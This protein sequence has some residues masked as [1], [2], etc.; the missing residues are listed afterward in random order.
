MQTEAGRHRLIPVDVVIIGLNSSPTLAACIESV[1]S[2]Q[3]GRA[4]LRVIYVDGGSTDGSVA[5]A[6]SHPGVKIVEPHPGHPAPG[7]QRNAGWRAGDA[8]FVQ[9]MDAD[10][11]LEPGW[12]DAALEAASAGAGA[13]RGLRRERRPGASV[14]NWIADQE[15]NAPPGPCEDFGGDA[16][17]RREA[18]ERTG[19]YD[20]T[21][22]GGEDPELSRR[23]RALGYSILA[24]DAPMTTHD[25]AMTTWRQYARRAFRTGYGYAAVYHR[26]G[27]SGFW[28]REV[29]RIAVRGG[30]GL[31]CALASAA[32]L[33]AGRPASA[34]LALAACALLV[35]YPRLFSV[36]RMARDKRLGSREAAVYAWHC[37]LVVIPEFFGLARYAFGVL[38]ESPLRNKAPKAAA[39]LLLGLCALTACRGV[40]PV[41]TPRENL[42][43]PAA[44]APT[45]SKE[46]YASPEAVEA[47][48]RMVDDQYRIGPGDILKLQV[49]NRPEI[50]NPNVVVGPDGAVTVNRIG[51]VH[52]GGKTVDQA[53][54]EISSRLGAFYERPEVALSVEKFNNNKAFVLGRVTSPG[55]VHFPGR[56]SLLE[57]LALAGGLPVL[58][59]DAFLTKCSIIR[60]RDT[61]IWVDLRD[62]LNNGNIALNARLQNNDIVFIPESEDELI[63]VMGEVKNPGAIRLKS[64]LTFMDALMMSGG[65]TREASMENIYLVR[66]DGKQGNVIQISLKDMLNTGNMSANYAL[67]A[68]D[69]I[70]VDQTGMSKFNYA[71][72]QIMPSLQILQMGTSIIDMGTSI[73][74]RW[75]PRYDGGSSSTDNLGFVNS[76]INTQ[77]SATTKTTGTGAA[78]G[79]AP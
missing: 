61:I 36:S 75:W 19:G 38:S 5:L 72:Q 39:L 22:V 33:P 74:Q 24:L 50:T 79:A 7:L 35:L 51:V 37:S 63:Y 29:R 67:K 11:T 54:K 53:A 42:T 30:G 56:G 76:I 65:P 68:N 27:G 49:W 52:I 15:W 16:F 9:F 3:T 21:L 10:T 1:L 20:E 70:Y 17:V 41:P 47:F 44:A 71:L 59:K 73:H 28:G 8:P 45:K 55:V 2:H 13:V 48:S 34:A 25:L 66:F 46:L 69:V 32:L 31:L 60:G 40:S 23:I 26:H 12:I 64:T 18:L 77:P 6:R 43:A 57:A 4:L 14:Y 62:L 78:T 58:Q